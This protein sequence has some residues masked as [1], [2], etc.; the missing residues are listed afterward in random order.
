MFLE[1]LSVTG[2]RG[3][4]NMQ[5]L[6]LA[7][8][9]GEPG[10][11]LSIV[12][13]PNNGGKS[14]LLESIFLVSRAKPINLPADDPTWNR[15]KIESQWTGDVRV[16]LQAAEAGGS[17]LTPIGGTKAEQLPLVYFLP[18]RRDLPNSGGANSLSAHKFMEQMV[19]AALRNA[20]P[21][22]GPRLRAACQNQ[23]KFDEILFALTG[24]EIRIRVEGD[25]F[26][27][28][29]MRAQH[30]PTGLGSGPCSLMQLAL[31]FSDTP[32]GTI[33]VI[34][35]PELSL[36]PALQKR[37]LE[38]LVTRSSN[39]Q[40]IYATHSPL[41]ISWKAILN[42]GALARVFRR[43]S[44]GC[45]IR[46]PT[47]DMIKE[48]EGLLQN[49]NNPHILDVVAKEVF[50]LPD[51][52]ILVEGQE[53]VFCY[54]KMSEDLEV[55]FDGEFFG[56]GIGGADNMPKICNL[57]RELGYFKVTA[58]LDKNMES[59]LDGLRKEFKDY[60]FHCISA[61]NVRDKRAKN[62]VKS[63]RGLC[64]TAG[65]IH[66]ESCDEVIHMLEGIGRYF[67]E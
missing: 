15:V 5:H 22:F 30:R 40:I 59:R 52:V 26:T 66:R 36:H 67:S 61:N 34:D 25:Q 20:T 28:R 50:F 57:L 42:G 53:D 54:R 10:S 29:V 6:R 14:A 44:A 8:P 60:R 33:V 55:S 47:P 41:L 18:P 11:G 2:Y 63:V 39:S 13:G 21:H 35:E 24:E 1:K 43:D 64:D 48:L 7:V 37:L 17:L 9:T 51:R 31:A 23:E 3:F 32:E 16:T 46:Q 56:W 4:E 45:I 62:A 65:K 12:V 49:V 27:L 38:F 58:I 19:S